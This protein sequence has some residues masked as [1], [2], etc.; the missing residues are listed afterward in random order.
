MRVNLLPIFLIQLLQ[1]GKLE[2]ELLNLKGLLNELLQVHETF[3][4][5]NEDKGDTRNRF[6]SF[7]TK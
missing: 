4:Q 1:I 3:S 2:Y 5:K 7:Y 6:A